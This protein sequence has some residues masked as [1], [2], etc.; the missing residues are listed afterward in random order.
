MK[1]GAPKDWA[2]QTFGYL[3]AIRDVGST[4]AKRLWEYRCRCGKLVI[5][6]GARVAKSTRAGHIASCGCYIGELRRTHGMSGHPA[7]AIWRSML[8]R[9]R[10]ST[11]QAW[12]NYGARGIT[13]CSEWQTFD[14]FW[15][16]MG[17]T[18][19]PGLTIDRRDNEQGYSPSNCEWRTPMEQCNNKRNNVH[20]NTPWGR[21]TVAQ[22]ARRSGLGVTTLHYRLTR[23][24]TGSALFRVPDSGSR[25]TISSTA[26]PG[27][28]S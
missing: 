28:N 14:G 13:V 2:G 27:A 26:D 10:L 11:H 19:Q 9:C 22:A 17:A 15:S 25:F 6:Q 12:H 1:Q 21:M 8:D 3:T 23:G 24:V 18:Y 4:G 16:D 20:I 5:R 7:F